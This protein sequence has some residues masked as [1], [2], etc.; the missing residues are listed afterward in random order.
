MRYF[1]LC[2]KSVLF[3]KEVMESPEFK[4]LI[5]V[6]EEIS[7]TIPDLLENFKKAKEN[8]E[9]VSKYSTYHPDYRSTKLKLISA[10]EALYT[11]ELVLKYK[12]LEKIIQTKLNDAALEIVKAI[13]I[14]SKQ[15]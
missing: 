11:N 4:E 10:K 8:Y 3:A 9:E 15:V 2:D 5:L 1:E 13:S 14:N 6:K 7:R 12:E